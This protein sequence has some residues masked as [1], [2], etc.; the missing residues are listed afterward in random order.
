MLLTDEKVRLFLFSTITFRF[1]DFEEVVY[2]SSS[3]CTP[4]YLSM[5]TVLTLSNTS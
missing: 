2:E 1:I 5:L 4:M 3:P